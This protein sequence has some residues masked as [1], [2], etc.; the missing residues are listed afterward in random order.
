MTSP[1]GRVI[2]EMLVDALTT[3]AVPAH[4]AGYRPELHTP[5]T[6]WVVLGEQDG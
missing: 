4:V 3:A 1:M 5:S 2:V 6:A